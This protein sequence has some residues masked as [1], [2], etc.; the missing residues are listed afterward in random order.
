MAPPDHLCTDYRGVGSFSA[1]RADGPC[2]V[3]KSCF[4]GCWEG[5][6]RGWEKQKAVDPNSCQ[7]LPPM[8]PFYFRTFVTILSLSSLFV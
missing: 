1:V 7:H 4:W 6:G 2:C 8:P 5:G 3:S